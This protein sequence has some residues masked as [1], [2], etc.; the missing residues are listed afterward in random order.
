MIGVADPAAESD[1]DVI[2]SFH[3][4]EFDADHRDPFEEEA[5]HHRRW[6]V[7]SC[8]AGAA[9][10]LFVGSA[11]G[12]L[13]GA[14]G[15]TGP[16]YASLQQQPAEFW[17]RPSANAKSDFIG[18]MTGAI[19]GRPYKRISL[20][21]QAPAAAPE[22]GN[23][24]VLGARGREGSQ[25]PGV[26]SDILPY[27]RPQVSATGLRT[28][29]VEVG[30]VTVITKTDAPEPYDEVVKLKKGESIVAT[31]T[32]LGTTIEAAQQLAQAMEP[33]YPT[34]L[35]REGMELTITLEKRVDLYGQDV[36]YPVRLA[37]SPDP[38]E[39]VVV[40]SDE[41]GQFLARVDEEERL[42]RPLHAA[43]PQLRAAGKIT[44]SFYQAAK[45]QGLP[46]YIIAEI[47]RVHAYDVDF[48]RQVKRGD[49]FEV[50]YGQPPGPNSANRKVLLYT[51]LTLDG[52]TKG[53]YRFTTAD[54]GIT[55][56]Y[57]E[58]GRSA[59]KALIRTP[60]NTT[61][62]SSGFG[63]RRH[64]ILGYTKMHSGVD[65]AAP[66][67]TPIKAAGDA[68]VEVAGRV[69]AYGKYVELR[70]ANGYA[71]RYA[72]MSRIAD[73]IAP[74]SR[75][76]QGQVIGYVGSTGRATGPHLHY[77]IHL[78]DRPVNPL[79]VRTA[80]ARQL[81]GKFLAAFKDQKSNVEALLKTSPTTTQV[82]Q[83]DG[84]SEGQAQ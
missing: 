79:H 56:Y 74:G 46:E 80:G 28:A 3:V 67:G 59:T 72:H 8:V 69:G 18:E 49:G 14:H 53:Y 25:Y 66:Y 34:R 32:R 20:G 40:E 76:R 44:G 16:E 61:K 64:P 1:F 77:E 27:G 60:V 17:Q 78:N 29:A 65:F 63:F 39:E 30:N 82:A 11:I 75:V 12:G 48:Q 51:S 52:E 38:K 43:A 73:S 9:G 47:M 36:L 21:H 6:L 55:E 35:L 22:S 23:R 4:D 5:P 19:A 81:T 41:N 24:L 45:E 37:F 15:S 54:D 42:K 26:T 10:M 84:A 58:T 70:H 57:D 68:T 2:D 71:T 13:F 7:T 62:I 33:V 83:A 31:L 50:L